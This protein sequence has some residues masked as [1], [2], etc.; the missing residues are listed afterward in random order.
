M[1]IGGFDVGQVNEKLSKPNGVLSARGQNETPSDHE[2]H[3]FAHHKTNTPNEILE[4][5]NT[6]LMGWSGQTSNVLA[7]TTSIGRNIQ[8]DNNMKY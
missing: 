6:G 7:Q 2:G 5:G 4:M 1:R 8:V 3:K